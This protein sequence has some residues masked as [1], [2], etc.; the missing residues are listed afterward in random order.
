[1]RSLKVGPIKPD[2]DMVVNAAKYNS[3]HLIGIIESNFAE[4]ATA[5]SSDK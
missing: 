4:E 2:R 5:S 1:M 3:W